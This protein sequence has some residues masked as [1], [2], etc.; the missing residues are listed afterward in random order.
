LRPIVRPVTTRNKA[1]QRTTWL[2][3]FIVAAGACTGVW[4]LSAWQDRETVQEAAEAKLVATARMLEQHAD[5]ALEAGDQGLRAVVQLVGDPRGLAAEGTGAT[6]HRRLRDLVAGNPT[7]S[8]AWVMDPGGVIIAETAADPPKSQG[9]FAFRAYFQ[10]HRDG[11]RGVHIGQLAVGSGTARPRFT[12]SRALTAPDGSFAGVAAIGVY[13]GYFA[14]VYAETGLGPGARFALFRED[15]APLALWPPP[16]PGEPQTTAIFPAAVPPPGQGDVHR[17][18]A[19]DL[20]A[21]RHLARFPAILAVSQPMSEVMAE[22]RTRTRRSGAAILAAVGTLAALTVLGLRGARRQRALTVALRAERSA[23]ERRVAD[24]TAALAESEA[25]FREMADNAPVMVWVTDTQGACV[26]L[27]RSWTEFTGQ[28]RAQGLG[29]GWLEAVHPEDRAEA[30]AIFRDALARQAAFRLEY[31]LRWATD[32]A[33]RWA[34]DAAL[35][36]RGPSGEFLG[37]VGSVIDIT[38]RREAEER[39]ALMARELD[40]RA[41]NALTVVQAALRLTPRTD[42]E[43]YARAVEGRV[44][45]LARAHSVLAEGR[46]Q[47]VALRALV[48]AELAAFLANG[49]LGQRVRLDGPDLLLVPPAVQAL[50]MALHELATN[51]T[52]YGALSVPAGRLAVTWALDRGAGLLRLAWVERGGAVIEGPPVRR[53][54][55][56]RVIEAT[57]QG[58]LG[59]QVS[60]DWAEG[61]A[62]HVALPAARVLVSAAGAAPARAAREELPELAG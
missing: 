28:P 29:F 12:L 46:W 23:L 5:R 37:H 57:L 9:S 30:G 60:R 32:G 39:Q 10:A 35:P 52:K 1:L 54:F 43:S 53:G 8:A 7:L 36:R 2:L 47:G 40:H 19:G 25:R 21:I 48:E 56:S 49:E 20:V 24:R 59:G 17:E 18:P 51:A 33:W 34:I 11:E 13:S 44:A 31:R 3:A 55:G 38:E 4:A 27:S 58:Q 45:A 42:L 15:G 41:K 62:C 6:L 16:V 50:S 26:F 22:W 14:E 61:L